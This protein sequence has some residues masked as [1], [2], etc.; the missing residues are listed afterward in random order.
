[1]NNHTLFSTCA[2]PLL[3]W[4]YSLGGVLGLPCTIAVERGGGEGKGGEGEVMERWICKGRM[5]PQQ[6]IEN[7]S[8]QKI[9]NTRAGVH[10]YSLSILVYATTDPPLHAH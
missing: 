2:I 5:V 3:Q 6:F 10:T 4:P 9:Q 8:N 1:M 7:G